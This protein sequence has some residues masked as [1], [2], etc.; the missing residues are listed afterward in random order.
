MLA[1]KDKSFE[2][3]YRRRGYLHFDEPIA[4]RRI[5]AFLAKPENV[6]RHSF[7]PLI[8]YQIKSHK[9]ARNPETGKLTRKEKIREIAYPSH[10]DSH[11]Y[12]YYSHKLAEKYEAILQKKKLSH[13]IL[14][15][16]SLG[17]SNIDF[18]VQAFR[19]IRDLGDCTAVCL[20]IR[21]F[22]DH[23]DHAQLKKSWNSLLEVDNLPS[24]HFSI[25]KS[26]TKYS[27]TPRTPLYKAFGISSNNPKN[28]GRRICSPLDFRKKVR[29]GKLIE[30]NINCYGIP[31]GTP[32]SAILSNIYMLE[33]DI[34]ISTLVENSGGRYFR[35]CDDILI[36]TPH[37]DHEYLV[38]SAMEEIEEL[39]LEIN[40]KKTEIRQFR[41]RGENLESNKPLQYLGF[42]F[43]GVKILLRSAALAKFSEKMKSGV[44]L[45]VATAKSRSHERVAHGRPIRPLYKRKLYERYSHLGEKNFVRY[46]LRA[47]QEMNSRHIREQL[48]PLWARLQEE[49]KTQA[50]KKR[51]PLA[52][53]PVKQA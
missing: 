33:F 12:S 31:Q 1:K 44:R 34:K 7:Y 46:G 29:G 6:G 39:K 25:F 37:A 4:M 13:A 11:I 5:A 8:S 18:A 10:V 30:T 9:I 22:F 53:T 15:F 23:I 28:H 42:T 16:R 41:R 49:I 32:I 52:N 17:K 38:A 27:K 26:I 14:A 2:T 19:A 51:V 20:D 50:E 48:K 36:I 21:G 40:T 43:D 35:Y 24:D 45:A 47:A 3:W